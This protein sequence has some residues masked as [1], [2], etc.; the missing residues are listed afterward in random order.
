MKQ[1]LYLF[2]GGDEE[3]GKLSPEE[4]QAHMEKWGVWMQSVKAEGFPLEAEGM[5]VAGK[6]AVVSNGPF[7]EGAEV[8][9]GYVILPAKDMKHAVELTKGCPILEMDGHIE[10]RPVADMPG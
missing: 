1:F 10:V 7:A 4:F 3:Y 9:G 8:V 6:S 2:R 5:Q